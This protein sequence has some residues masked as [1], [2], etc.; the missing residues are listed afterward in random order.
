M[1]P[2]SD[3]GPLV[4]FGWHPGDE[5]VKVKGGSKERPWE[6]VVHSQC[7]PSK[8]FR[9]NRIRHVLITSLV[10]ASSVT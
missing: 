2:P 8:D 3:S 1:P 6:S 9:D 10:I 5:L 7:E 4:S